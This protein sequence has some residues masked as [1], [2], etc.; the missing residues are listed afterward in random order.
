MGEEAKVY[1]QYARDNGILV[2][3]AG[4]RIVRLV[5]PLI[6]GTESIKTFNE[7]LEKFLKG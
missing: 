2:N 4:G 1:Q 7:C 3:V 5:P 6:V